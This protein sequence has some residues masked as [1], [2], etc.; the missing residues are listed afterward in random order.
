MLHTF[1]LS[2]PPRI[3]IE[4]RIRPPSSLLSQKSPCSLDGFPKFSPGHKTLALR[5]EGGVVSNVEEQ[6]YS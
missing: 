2:R 6:S 4:L 1:G 3:R 5:D